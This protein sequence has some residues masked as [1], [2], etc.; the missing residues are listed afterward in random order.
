M[1]HYHANDRGMR[2]HPPGPFYTDCVE[3]IGFDSAIIRDATGFALAKVGH[4]LQKEA[5]ATAELFRSSPAMYQRLV[6]AQRLLLQQDYEGALEQINLGL[7]GNY[8]PE[9]S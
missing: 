7:S 1:R 8:E 4:Y 3:A 2:H 9:D 6:L 5:D